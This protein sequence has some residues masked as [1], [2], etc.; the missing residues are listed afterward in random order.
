[1]SE[2]ACDLQQTIHEDYGSLFA[3]DYVLLICYVIWIVCMYNTIVHAYLV[4]PPS[5]RITWISSPPFIAAFTFLGPIVRSLS[6]ELSNQNVRFTT[7]H[8]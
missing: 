3:T 4:T 8:I 1:M 5:L 7:L 2:V 6:Q